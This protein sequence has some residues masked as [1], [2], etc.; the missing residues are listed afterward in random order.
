MSEV[1]GRAG[2]LRIQNAW[3]DGPNTATALEITDAQRNTE[4]EEFPPTDQ[5]WLQLQHLQDCLDNGTPHRIPPADSITQ[6]RVIDAAVYASLK[7][8][9]PAQLARLT[10]RVDAYAVEVP[11]SHQS[12]MRAVVPPST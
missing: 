1:L 2:R 6:M 11:W 9:K 3:G 5:F 8:G 4:V 12:P 10:D 7:T